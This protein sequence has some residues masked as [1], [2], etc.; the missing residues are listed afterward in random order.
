MTK[1][2]IRQLIPQREPILMIDEL[3]S[4]D[5]NNGETVFKIK[6]DNIFLNSA[7]QF[8]ETGLIENI[9]QSAS[10]VA[11]YRALLNGATNPPVGYIGEIKKFRR[12]HQ[13]QAGDELSTRIK[14]G[15]EV[16]GVTMLTGQTYVNGVMAA[17]TQMKIYIRP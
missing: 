3:V 5:E 17:E 1:V 11:G 15:V 13:P 4:A 6:P 10:A 14:L 2:D 12:Y 9:A 7:G 8:E 16:N